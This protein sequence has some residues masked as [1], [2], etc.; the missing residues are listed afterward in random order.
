MKI[1]I[2]AS[3]SGELDVIHSPDNVTLST[4]GIGVVSTTYNLVKLLRDRYDLVLNIGIAGSFSE[5]LNVGD[6]VVV[7]SETFGDFGVATPDGFR[8][9]FEEKIISPCMFPFTHGTLISE[10]AEQAALTMS[11]RAVRA[12]TNNTVSAEESLIRRM[13]FKYSPAIETM[14]G[15]AFF[16]VCLREHVPFVAIRSIS[17]MVVP[18]DKSGWDIP[19]ALQSLSDKVNQYLRSI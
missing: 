8:T 14:E 4:T 7:S 19:L 15:A 1:L 17:N 2:T 9:C 11:I 13:K 18:R 3:T 6:V 5:S 10:H 16:Y 12:I